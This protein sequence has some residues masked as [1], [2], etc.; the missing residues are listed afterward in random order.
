MLIYLDTNVWERPFDK[1]SKRIIREANALFSI[2]EKVFKGKLT[3]MSSVILDVEVG[4]IEDRE[5]K[6]AT[7]QLITLFASQK[8]YTIS[9]SK[10]REI[11]EITGL[12]L[13][14]AAHLACAIEAG[15]KYFITCDNEIVNKCQKIES[16]YGLK[17]LNPINFLRLGEE[18]W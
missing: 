6:R 5:K 14:D 4:N 7:E 12:K 10:T 11:K 9:N 16:Q 13:P 17:I 15:C 1:P 2:L 8:V 18:E 3:I